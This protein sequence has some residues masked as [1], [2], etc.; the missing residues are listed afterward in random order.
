MPL[1][2]QRLEINRGRWFRRC[3]VAAES[4]TVGGGSFHR[5]EKMQVMRPRFRP[6][7]PRMRARVR[8]DAARR[9]VG[10]GTAG[11]VSLERATIIQ[12]FVAEQFAEAF[13]F[14]RPADQSV[15]VEV[16][17][18]MAKVADQSAI[19]FAE[20]ETA[21][22]AFVVVSLG[23]VQRHHAPVVAG[24]DLSVLVRVGEK[25]EAQRRSSRGRVAL[26]REGQPQQGVEAAAL[27][28]FQFAPAFEIPRHGKVGNHFRHA[29]GRAER[30][31]LA[32]RRHPIAN[33]VARP[34][35]A[36]LVFARRIADGREV[37]DDS[38]RAQ[39][40]EHHLVGQETKLGTALQAETVLEK[41]RVPA[42]VTVKRFHAPSWSG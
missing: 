31:G 19:R 33:L 23:D 4:Q 26:R 39:C 16:A 38:R 6:V 27:G 18:L 17:Q 3:R 14:R 41:N 8:R 34:V 5:V 10:D 28:V 20:I 25:S 37:A 11:V 42:N 15:P 29:T 9:P 32:D 21:A 30:I 40:G 7:L 13:Q 12:S 36:A 1:L 2:P 22:L 35:V 24:Q